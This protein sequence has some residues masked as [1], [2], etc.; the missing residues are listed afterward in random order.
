MFVQISIR[1]LFR[2]HQL[3]VQNPPN[4]VLFVIFI[5]A[6]NHTSEPLWGV[7]FQHANEQHGHWLG[8]AEGSVM[9]FF[10]FSPR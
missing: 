2:F 5:Q 9:A 3:F 1:C 6:V 4:D 7:D 10:G 8:G